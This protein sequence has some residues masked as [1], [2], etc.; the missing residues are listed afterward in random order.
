MP[1][2]PR[3]GA[4]QLP[5]ALSPAPAGADPPGIDARDPDQVSA[6]W[7]SP[8]QR[9]RWPAQFT[10]LLGL[11]REALATA[12]ARLDADELSLRVVVKIYTGLQGERCYFPHPDEVRRLLREAAIWRDFDGRNVHA[13]A[14]R[15]RLSHQQVYKIL[16][17]Q[18]AARRA[19]RRGE[20]GEGLPAA[21]GRRND[22]GSPPP[23]PSPHLPPDR[24]VH[25][26]HRADAAAIV[27]PGPP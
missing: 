10:T 20:D 26:R 4:S 15:Y 14:R 11:V 24:R 25:G 23:S 18:R 9:V 5:L 17:R 16:K 6:Y 19:G 7:F 3:P 22:T 12:P 8:S 2:A 21:G 1:A 13:L 27:T